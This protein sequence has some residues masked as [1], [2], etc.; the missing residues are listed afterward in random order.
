[1]GTWEIQKGDKQ[2]IKKQKGNKKQKV[3][4]SD[5][6]G[7]L[8]SEEVKAPDVIPEKTEN[9]VKK[10]ENKEK[11]LK[12]QELRKEKK[13]KKKAALAELRESK[14]GKSETLTPAPPSTPSTVPVDDSVSARAETTSNP[15]VIKTPKS[16]KKKKVSEA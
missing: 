14:A 11:V 15:A 13:N 1:M 12:K 16:K 7:E 2:K 6:V 3:E 8:T 4:V 10:K 9:V 5:S